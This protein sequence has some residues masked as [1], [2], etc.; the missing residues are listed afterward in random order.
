MT[1]GMIMKTG[2][3][4]KIHKIVLTPYDRWTSI[5]FEVVA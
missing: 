3:K 4:Q 5:C 1:L 2:G